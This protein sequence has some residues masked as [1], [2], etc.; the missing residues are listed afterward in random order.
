MP[1][2]HIDLDFEPI[3]S[4]PVSEELNTQVPHNSIISEDN[5]IAA[6]RK[7]QSRLLKVH[8]ILGHLGF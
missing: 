5:N 3:K 1:L 4:T 6:Y 8:E 2:L 7:K